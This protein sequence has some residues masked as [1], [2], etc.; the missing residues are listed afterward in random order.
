MNVSVIYCYHSIVSPA[1]L[2]AAVFD[3]LVLMAC[4]AIRSLHVIYCFAFLFFS[5]FMLVLSPGASFAS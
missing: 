3:Y 4:N 2:H 5:Y 1:L